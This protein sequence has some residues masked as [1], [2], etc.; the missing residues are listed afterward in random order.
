MVR[1][2]REASGRRPSRDGTHVPRQDVARGMVG[3]RQTAPRQRPTCGRMGRRDQAMVGG[4][5]TAPRQRQAGNRTLGRAQGMVG[6]RQ[7]AP[8]WRPTRR[9]M[10][11][12]P[13][14][15]APV[16][17]FDCRLVVVAVSKAVHIPFLGPVSH[18]DRRFIVVVAV[19][20]TV[21]PPAICAIRVCC[22]RRHL[23]GG[24]CW[25]RG[26][27]DDCECCQPAGE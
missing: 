10:P 25:K 2:R 20:P 13:P 8:R 9:G 16:R 3:E 11:V 19:Q 4:W 18:F 5:Q 6:G 14:F 7:T 21:H 15:L 24:A 27:Y 23:G 17:A 1:G 26:G 12:H 22:T